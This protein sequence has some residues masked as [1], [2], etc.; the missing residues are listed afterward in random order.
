[1]GRGEQVRSTQPTCLC[2]QTL[3][4]KKRIRE[5]GLDLPQLGCHACRP[6]SPCSPLSRG[7]ACSACLPAAVGPQSTWGSQLAVLGGLPSLCSFLGPEVLISLGLMNTMCHRKLQQT[8]PPKP[9]LGRERHCEQ[10]FGLFWTSWPGSDENILNLHVY[11]HRHKERGMGTRASRQC[12]L[13]SEDNGQVLYTKLLVSTFK[14]AHTCGADFTA[15]FNHLRSRTDSL[16]LV[17]NPEGSLWGWEK[18]PWV[19]S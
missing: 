8:Y 4:E 6:L 15:P 18:Q 1:M 3:T 17:Q 11:L 5:T 19:R 9:F 7:L 12:L 10:D 2:S 13:Y 16:V 14:S